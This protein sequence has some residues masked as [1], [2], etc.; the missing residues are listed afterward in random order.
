MLLD[1]EVVDLVGDQSLA[2]DPTL[3]RVQ[4]PGDAA[5]AVGDEVLVGELV[6][7]LVD[8]RRVDQH[9]GGDVVGLGDALQP[10]RVQREQARGRRMGHTADVTGGVR[11]P[12]GRG[13]RR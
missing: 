4:V 5:V 7:H 13:A 10:Q 9:V 12:A 3:G 8:G 11:G 6:E 2:H 1:A